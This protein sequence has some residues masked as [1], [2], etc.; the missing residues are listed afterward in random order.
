M[1][2]DIA[3]GA[4]VFHVLTRRHA[5]RDQAA[6]PDTEDKVRTKLQHVSPDVTCSK[7]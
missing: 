5:E 4:G 3:A 2:D 1:Q 7:Q 6:R